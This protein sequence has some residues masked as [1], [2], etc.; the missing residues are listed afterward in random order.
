MALQSSREYCTKKKSK[1]ASKKKRSTAFTQLSGR[2]GKRQK[3]KAVDDLKVAAMHM[4]V[5]VMAH[6]MAEAI[7]WS[8]EISAP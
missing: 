5:V 8:H 7:L 1:R 4:D 2:E 6:A 3:R